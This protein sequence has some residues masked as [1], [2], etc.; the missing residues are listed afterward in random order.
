MQGRVPKIEV[1]HLYKVLNAQDSRT[2]KG[3]CRNAKLTQARFPLIIRII[4]PFA[5]LASYKVIV[6]PQMGYDEL[7]RLIAWTTASVAGRAVWR[8][9]QLENDICE[10]AYKSSSSSSLPSERHAG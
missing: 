4:Y 6:E 8:L 2:W 7:M 9:F 1:T 3:P 5:M 10:Y